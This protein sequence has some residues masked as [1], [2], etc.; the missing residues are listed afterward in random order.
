VVRWLVGLDGPAPRDGDH[1]V[2]PP[3]VLDVSDIDPAALTLR[4]FER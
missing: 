2:V 1:L 3:V 4:D